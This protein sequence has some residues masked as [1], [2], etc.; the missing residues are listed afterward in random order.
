[1]SSQGELDQIQKALATED[2][3]EAEA[4]LKP[5]LQHQPQAHAL[6][7]LLGF[8][9]FMQGKARDAELVLRQALQQGSRQFWTP[10][11]LGDA[12]RAQQRLLA[13]AE[14]YEQAL[15]W[16]SDS[17]LTV[18][19][20]LQVLALISN[21]LLLQRL[22]SFVAGSPSP[23]CWDSPLPWQ[24]GAI[25]ACLGL[26]HAG[27]ALSLAQQGCR[28]VSVRKLACADALAH[29]D[30]QAAMAF[31]S[32]ELPAEKMLSQRLERLLC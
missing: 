14:A 26:G 9:L 11:K 1:M 31:L 25:E 28:H 13:A 12:L 17:F 10:H 6:L 2:W 3:L 21:D 32:A 23:L 19:N 30:L 29:L 8:S 22:N 15:R 7:D 18:R 27:L 4:L 20:L 5:L 24:R 16:G